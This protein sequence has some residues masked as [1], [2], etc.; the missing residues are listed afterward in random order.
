[1]KLKGIYDK[2]FVLELSTCNRKTLRVEFND[3]KGSRY[4]VNR[5]GREPI[6]VGCMQSRIYT[7]IQYGYRK[8]ILVHC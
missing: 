1:M 7:R 3:R 8:Y 2:I 6:S 5:I 4:E